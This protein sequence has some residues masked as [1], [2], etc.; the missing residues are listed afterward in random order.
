[1]RISKN[2]L[3]LLLLILLSLLASS[4]TPKTI[5]KKI[6]D[7]QPVLPICNQSKWDGLPLDTSRAMADQMGYHFRVLKVQDI[8]TEKDEYQFSFYDKNNGIL[9]YSETG[10]NQMLKKGLMVEAMTIRPKDEILYLNG[11]NNPIGSVSIYGNKIYFASVPNSLTPEQIQEYKNDKRDGFVRIPPSQIIGRSR[12]YEADWDGKK[13]TNEKI[14]DFNSDFDSLYAWESHPAISPD[15]KILFFSSNRGGGENGAG[16][17]GTDI[18]YSRKKADGNWEEPINCGD[19]INTACD[20]M[21]P[22]IGGKK[23]KNNRLYFASSGHASLGGYDIFRSDINWEDSSPFSK[24][25]NLRPPLNSRY[26]ELFPTTNSD[27]DSLIYF[28]SNRIN[29]ENQNNK[30]TDFD[31]YVKYKHWVREIEYG[32]GIP[33]EDFIVEGEIE[34][35]EDEILISE[36]DEIINPEPTIISGNIQSEDGET[37]A[38]ASIRAKTIATG[39]IQN[40]IKSDEKGN[41]NLEIKIKEDTEVIA[42]SSGYFFDSHV[43]TKEEL[44]NNQKINVDLKLPVSLVLRINFPYDNSDSPYEFTLDSK[45]VQTQK[46]FLMEL[47][48]LANNIKKSKNIKEIIL[49]GHTDFIGSNFYNDELGLERVRFIL[50]YLVKAGIDEKLFNY[51]SAGKRE[52]LDRTEGES[53]EIYRKRLRRVTIE[54]IYK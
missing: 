44:E 9:T 39:E 11:T 43:I 24:A 7:C 47:A 51:R 14:L 48:N 16:F 41:Y 3:S 12:I 26:D 40:E 46:T 35:A 27:I 22:F 34:L 19:K 49:V 37:I 50:D 36:P 45:G 18:W 8:D 2:I 52:M 28:S 6:L 38:D 1:M 33:E 20:E 5:P 31:I 29:P 13:I 10:K 42:E 4:C 54:K 17:G 15:G 53:D 25:T 21:T 30:K 32:S 23:T